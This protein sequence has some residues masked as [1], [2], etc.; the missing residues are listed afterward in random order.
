MKMNFTKFKA[1]TTLSSLALIF[2]TVAA[3][4]ACF[5]FLYQPEEPKGLKKLKKF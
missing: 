2:S 5:F 1:L 3:N 4:S